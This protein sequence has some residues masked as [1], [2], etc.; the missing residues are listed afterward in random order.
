MAL[1]EKQITS[2]MFRYMKLFSQRLP[3]SPSQDRIILLNIP[4]FVPVQREEEMPK[5]KYDFLIRLDLVKTQKRKFKKKKLSE[6]IKMKNKNCST[7]IA[8]W[9]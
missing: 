2:H 6:I 1:L 9:L 8:Y 3:L 5:Q 7:G 4:T